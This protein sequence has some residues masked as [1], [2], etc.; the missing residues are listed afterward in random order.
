[1]LG[2]CLVVGAATIVPA[3]Y[4]YVL[5][6]MLDG[7]GAS[8]S[9]SS[10]LRQLPSI[11]ALLVI[12][13]AGVLGGRWGARRLISVGAVMF[14]AGS[15]AV[16]LAPA[17]PVAVAGLVIESVGAS[18][19]LVVAL[20]L[21][22]ASVNDAEARASAF[23]TFAIV[24]PLVY[25]TSPLAA[26]AIV[27]SC[28]WRFVP[29]LWVLGGLV[30]WWSTRRLLPDDTRERSAGE[31]VTPALAG[32][33]LAG[34][35]QA[36]NAVQ[37]DGWTSTS[38]LVR[39]GITIAALTALIAVFRRATAPS[40]STAALQQGGMLILLVVVIIIPFANL[41]FYGTMGFQYVYGLSV[42][43]TAIVMVP[44]QLAGVLG[45]M[46]IRR[47]IQ[48]RGITIS[49]FVAL[50]LLALSLLSSCLIEVDTPI[51]LAVAVLAGYGIASVGSGIP[52]TNSIMDTAPPGE[53]GSASAFRGAASNLGSAVGVV[54]MTTIVFG[55]IS[56]SLTAELRQEGLATQQSADIAA[57]IRDGATSEN[58]AADYSVP[59]QEVDQ[60]SDAQRIAMVDGLHAQGQWGAAFIGVAAVIFLLGRRRQERA[61][62]R[63]ETAAV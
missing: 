36:V 51:A 40:L 63:T 16:A 6:P 13:L 56:T 32:L 8:E 46:L 4:N 38:T 25:T 61:T 28:S 35:V 18:A 20:G 59:V 26:G 50:T 17:F 5:D 14:T 10:L 58:V 34:A 54:V 7:L 31:L 27:D 60:I 52:L 1:M 21:L 30:M 47:L 57:Q 24:A 22:S 44:A 48:R 9:Q 12:F 37:H 55:V 29:A 15:A 23:A 42:L 53:D 43:Q 33:V 49:G 41:W 19:L 11:A 39:I 2:I 62:A 3:T 45:A